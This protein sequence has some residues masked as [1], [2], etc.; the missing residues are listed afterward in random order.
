MSYDNLTSMKLDVLKEIG[1]IGVGNATT[2]LSVMLQSNLAMETPVVRI[3]EFNEVADIIGGAD[4]IVAAVLTHFTGEVSGMTLFIM[5]V[6]EAKNMVSV[7]LNKTYPEDFVEFD[8][9]DESALKEVGNILMSSYV[10]SIS[11]LTGLEVRTDPPG[12]CVDMAG[13]VL[14]LPI[15]VLGQVGDKALIIDSKFVDNNRPIDGFI[16]FVADDVSF[17]RIFEAL[18]IGC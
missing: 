16:M 13:A 5:Q 1:N 3:L 17:D 6:E 8:H 7:M 14:S 9:M 4:S 15:S 2:A 18:G 12:I 10:S 11:T